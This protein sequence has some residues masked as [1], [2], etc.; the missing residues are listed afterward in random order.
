[1]RLKFGVLEHCLEI[2]KTMAVYALVVDAKG[3]KGRAFYEHNGF[4]SFKDNP[5]VMYFSLGTNIL[6]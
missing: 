5:M 6:Q 1:L 4:L 2:R 3:E